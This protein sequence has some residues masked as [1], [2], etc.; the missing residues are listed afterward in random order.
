MRT[1]FICTLLTVITLA[2]NAEIPLSHDN[3]LSG[4]RARTLPPDKFINKYRPEPLESAQRG[5]DGLSTQELAFLIHRYRTRLQSMIQNHNCSLS[6]VH[7]WEHGARIDR[8]WNG[9]FNWIA[10]GSSKGNGNRTALRISNCTRVCI[11]LHPE[12]SVPWPS[13]NDRV[14][15]RKATQSIRSYCLLQNLQQPA[16]IWMVTVH[17]SGQ[18]WAWREGIKDPILIYDLPLNAGK[19]IAGTTLVRKNTR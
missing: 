18:V 17:T 10:L 12:N 13:H 9:G 2:V 19:P 16:F 14:A 5:D 3:M 7:H 15:G 4:Q 11:H 8:S 6:V 1:I